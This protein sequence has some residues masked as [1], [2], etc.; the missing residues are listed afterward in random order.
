MGAAD[1]QVWRVARVVAPWI[2]I[3]RLEVARVAQL[4]AILGG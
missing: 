4:V 1:R 2:F 3:H